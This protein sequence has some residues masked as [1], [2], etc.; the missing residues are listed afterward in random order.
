MRRIFILLLLTA[1]TLSCG[2]QFDK[3]VKFIKH[4]TMLINKSFEL[5]KEIYIDK[6]PDRK[7]LSSRIEN[8]LNESKSLEPVSGWD[9][10]DTIKNNIVEA[11]TLDLRFNQTLDSL[12]SNNNNPDSKLMS[13]LLGATSLEMKKGIHSIIR[14]EFDKLKMQPE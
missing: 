4:S 8:F 6:F 9:V 3:K 2:D 5:S 7:L 14:D 11:F 13:A 10:S 12:Q 1:L